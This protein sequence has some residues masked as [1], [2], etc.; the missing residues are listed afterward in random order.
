[1][2]SA[3]DHDDHACRRGPQAAGRRLEPAAPA[4]L[5]HGRGMAGR[6]LVTVT[7]VIIVATVPF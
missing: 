2:I 1:M 7:T 3:T 4:V 6:A 5:L